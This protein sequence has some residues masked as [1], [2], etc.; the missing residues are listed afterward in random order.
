MEPLERKIFLTEIRLQCDFAFE[1]FKELTS[2]TGPLEEPFFRA[3]HS[4]LLNLASVTNLLWPRPKRMSGE[5]RDDFKRRKQFATEKGKDLRK[6]LSL[7]T[8]LCTF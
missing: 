4:F 8:M 1:S 3:A 7:P 2:L 5:K 6:L